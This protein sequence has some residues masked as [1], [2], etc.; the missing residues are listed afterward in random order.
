MQDTTLL[1]MIT[2]GMVP[3]R[4]LLELLH[5]E[6]LVL[7]GRDMG[8]MEHIL[9]QKQALV[10]LLEQHGRRRSQLLAGLGLPANRKGLQELAS[11]SDVGEQLIAASDELSALIAECQAINEQNGSLIQL[12][13]VT[14][15]HQLRILK[16][17][18]TPTLYDSRGSTAGRARPRPLSQA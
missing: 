15:A 17:A 4:Q 3:T 1:Q 7:H 2:D 12:Q 14:T 5:A 9:A 8:E 18:D 13:Q 10:I 16:G 6:S 11:H